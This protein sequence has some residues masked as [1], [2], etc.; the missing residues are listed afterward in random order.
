[1]STRIFCPVFVIFDKSLVARGI[2]ALFQRKISCFFAP[3]SGQ[4][5]RN[6]DFGISLDKFPLNLYNSDVEAI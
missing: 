1:L 2:R 4:I 6:R 3:V 5:I